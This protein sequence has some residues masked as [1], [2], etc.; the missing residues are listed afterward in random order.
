MAIQIKRRALDSH[1]VAVNMVVKENTCLLA[2]ILYKLLVMPLISNKPEPL[3]V[4]LQSA[5]GPQRA[6]RVRT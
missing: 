3:C 2:Y 1:A 4:Y 5:T 6:C